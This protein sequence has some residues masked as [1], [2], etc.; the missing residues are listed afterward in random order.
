MEKVDITGTVEECFLELKVQV[1]PFLLHTYVKRKQSASFKSLVKE[2]DGS[3]VVLQV[4]FSENATIA[5]Q[6]EIQSAHWNHGQATLFTAHAWIKHDG[7]DTCSMVIVSDDLNHTK[8]SVYVFMQRILT[9]LKASYPG[10][11]TIDIFSDGPTSQFKQRFLFSNLHGW[12]M[13]HDLKIRWNF[14]ATSH[15]KGMVDG[16]G[17]TLKRAVWRHVKAERAHVM[18]PSQH[19]DLG[20]Q[21]CPN[22]RIEFVSK[23]DIAQYTSFLDEKWENT[24]AVPGTHQVHCV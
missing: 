4:D 13:E 15:G 8:H 3:S 6:R 22:I 21:L 19:A 7:S 1:C 10:I 5:S 16:I 20:K 24:K 12:E 18:N 11:E 2:C 9:H 17:G 23:E 14:F